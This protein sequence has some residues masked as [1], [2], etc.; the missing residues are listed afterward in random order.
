M[1]LEVAV[2]LQRPGF[3]IRRRAVRSHRIPLRHQIPHDEAINFMKD[4]FKVE[5][6]EDKK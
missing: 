5:I 4:R 3:R 1:G 2:T 6:V